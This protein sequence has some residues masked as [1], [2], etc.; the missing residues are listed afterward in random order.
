MISVTVT[1]LLLVYVGK[2]MGRNSMHSV[3]GD[4]FEKI[5]FHHA[6]FSWSH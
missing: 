1:G 2:E 4:E 5:L 3:L 6:A